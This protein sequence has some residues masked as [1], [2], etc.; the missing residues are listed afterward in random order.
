LLQQT[1]DT[2]SSSSSSSSSSSRVRAATGRDYLTA[3]RRYLTLAAMMFWQGGFTFY[4]AVVIHVA[5]RVLGSHLV[6]GF[7]TQR[8]TNWLNFSGGIALAFALWELLAVRPSAGR[9][10][11]WSMAAAWVLMAVTLIVLVIMHPM[12]DRLLDA[13]AREITD[14]GQF[15]TLHQVYLAVATVQWAAALLYLWCMILQG[16]RPTVAAPKLT[17]PSPDR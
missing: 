2:L 9:V 5:H 1:A 11:W 15:R 7:V 12:L 13:Q 17:N 10:L 16:V 4:G 8:V 3:V 6:V 14:G